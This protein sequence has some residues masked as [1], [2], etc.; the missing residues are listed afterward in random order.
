MLWAMRYRTIS[1]DSLSGA[2]I[3]SIPVSESATALYIVGVSL[4]PVIAIGIVIIFEPTFNFWN[5]ST[6]RDKHLAA[7]NVLSAQQRLMAYKRREKLCRADT[8]IRLL[9]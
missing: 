9:E 7:D 4:G 6:I 1:P 2:E 5:V 3:K 8:A